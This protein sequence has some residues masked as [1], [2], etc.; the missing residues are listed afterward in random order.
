MIQEMVQATLLIFVAEMGDKTQILAMT[1]A[2]RYTVSQVLT[3]V[4]IGSFINHGLA[5]LLGAYLSTVIPLHIVRIVASVA[6]VGFGLW[7]LAKSDDN[8]DEEAAKAGNPILT[9]A[10]AFL[11]GEL[12]DKTQLTAIALSSN[13]NFPLFILFGT[14]LGMVLTSG[15]GIFVGSKLGERVPEVAMRLASSGVFIFFGVIGLANAL[16]AEFLTTKNTLVFFVILFTTVALI[17]RVL[18]MRNRQK[19]SRIRRVAGRL[20]AQLRA[21]ESS[22][23]QLCLGPEVCGRCKGDNCPVGQCKDLMSQAVKLHT[24]LI[25]HGEAD[26]RLNG[27]K[28]DEEKLLAAISLAKESCFYCSGKDHEQCVFSQTS[29]L[30]EEVYRNQ[31]K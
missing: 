14:T 25:T 6:F 1:F 19:K 16:P 5:V 7:T 8:D 23:N 11:I 3:G 27:K 12:G 28:F 18:V 15:V 2:L 10:M 22:I 20:L 9:V 17:G 31:K 13:A 29:K 24:H 30:L 4:F 21:V 26:F